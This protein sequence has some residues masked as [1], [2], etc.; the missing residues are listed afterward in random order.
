MTFPHNLNIMRLPSRRPTLWLIA[1]SSLLFF[2]VWIFHFSH[3]FENLVYYMP[4]H[5]I[6]ETISIVISVLIF[7][8]GWNAYVLSRARKVVLI[9][10]AFLSVAVLDLGH[11]MTYTG[12]PEFITHN[13]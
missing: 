6:L 10:C 12:M 11:S 13:H 8:V 2:F 9:S 5:T 3:P 4:L 1:L 7:S